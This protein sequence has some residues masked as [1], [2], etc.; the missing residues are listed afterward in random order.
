MAESQAAIRINPNLA[1]PHNTL[2]IALAQ[3]GR[4][5]DAIPEFEAVLRIDPAN[6]QA[7]ANLLR[8][9]AAMRASGRGERPR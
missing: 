5:A 7:S 3:M 1:E 9:R 6:A 2:G 8:A 4:I